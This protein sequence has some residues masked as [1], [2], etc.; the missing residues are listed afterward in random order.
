MS[1]A[2]L[3]V[4]GLTKAYAIGGRGFV[5]PAAV[6]RAL[7][8]VD[9]VVARGRHMGVVG[10]SGAGKSTLARCI[11]TLERPDEGAI[12][13]GDVD[14]L[15]DPAAAR[16]SLSMV[17]QDPASSL[18]PRWRALDIVAEPL[19]RLALAPAER[20]ARALAAMEAVGLGAGEAAKRPHEFSGGQRQRLA[21]ARAIVGRPALV[22]ADEPTSALDPSTAARLLDLMARLSDEAGVTF[23]VV[24]HDLHAIDRL[25][26]DVAVMREGRIVEAGTR[27]MLAGAA[28][29]DYARALVAAAGRG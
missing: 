28:R 23:L 17:F 1:D 15:A 29:D 24:S 19:V 10:E 20:R 27:A 11:A 14:A 6:R 8:R 26:D 9:L 22:I 18:D 5:R 25:C 7:D 21:F 4:R 16:A 3:D 2:L 12:R 13:V